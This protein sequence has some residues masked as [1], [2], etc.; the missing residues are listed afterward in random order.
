MNLTNLRY[1]SICV[2]RLFGLCV[3]IDRQQG[4][5]TFFGAGS[6]DAMLEQFT[7]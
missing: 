4:G 1:S 6:E 5:Q 7:C 3:S 2:R